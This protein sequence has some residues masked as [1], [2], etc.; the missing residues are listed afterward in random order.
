MCHGVISKVS[1]GTN[2]TS[3]IVGLCAASLMHQGRIMIMRKIL[4]TNDDGIY[5]EGIIRL[6]EAAQTFGEV[7]VVA[8]DGQ[9][10]SASHGISIHDSFDVY[11]KDFP[12]KGVHAFS[13]TGTPA[14]C[15]RS[16]AFYLMPCKPDVVL[17]GINNGYNTAS[18]I[19]YSGTCGAAFEGRF[20]G[21]HSIAF[22]EKVDSCREVTDAYLRK[23]LG[24]LID[25]RLGEGQ[26]YNVNFP[27]C[28][29]DELKGIKYDTA[30]SNGYFFSTAY[31]K[32]ADLENG[33]CRLKVNGEY[34]EDAPEGTDSRAVIDGYIS[35]S[36]VD[37]IK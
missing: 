21:I 6:A 33:G 2:R 25:K 17:S 4:I 27:G 28:K 19:Q 7:W 1:L 36:I 10:S 34:K 14:D 18:D 8:P 16:G 13:C 31:Q 29:L 3:R 32:I 26:I 9:R 11:P 35:V 15:I 20:Q 37:N 5:A 23:L 12:V 24:E 22:S 30:V